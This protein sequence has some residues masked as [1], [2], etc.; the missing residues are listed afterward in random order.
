MFPLFYYT[1]TNDPQ[2]PIPPPVAPSTAAGR[3]RKR[4]RDRR[5]KNIL[6]DPEFRLEQFE[7]EEIEQ[8]VKRLLVK[9]P[10]KYRKAAQA[11]PEFMVPTYA[12]TPIFDWYWKQPMLQDRPD[13]MAL[14]R[15]V[16]Q[17]IEHEDD[18]RAVEMMLRELF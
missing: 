4:M 17:Q 2:A 18:E 7:P 13:L 16:A 15:R 1:W 3:A 12:A 5:V 14:F 10:K 9:P 11:Q 6:E 8:E